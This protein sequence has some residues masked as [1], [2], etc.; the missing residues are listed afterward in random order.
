MSVHLKLRFS[1]HSRHGPSRCT[2]ALFRSA[3]KQDEEAT[4]WMVLVIDRS[5]HKVFS[6]PLGCRAVEGV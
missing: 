6:E 3:L 2:G 5:L 1:S 4:A